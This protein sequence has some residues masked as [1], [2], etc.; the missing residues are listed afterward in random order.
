[1]TFRR[2]FAIRS[3]PKLKK[4]SIRFFI[5]SACELAFRETHVKGELQFHNK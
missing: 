5:L 1:M 4:T 3:F 2:Y